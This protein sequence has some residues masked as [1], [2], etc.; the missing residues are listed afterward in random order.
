MAINLDDHQTFKGYVYETNEDNL[1]PDLITKTHFT[2]LK[3][4]KTLNNSF[5]KLTN[6]IPSEEL[7]Q[8]MFYL[9]G[10]AAIC[11]ELNRMLKNNFQLNKNNITIKP[12]W[13]KDKK[14]L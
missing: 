1:F 9:G 2:F 11:I 5:F 7:Q 3:K 4:N 10:D 8:T 6:N 14:G 12:F 13:K